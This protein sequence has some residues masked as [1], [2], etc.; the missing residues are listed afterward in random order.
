MGAD[1]CEVDLAGLFRLF[2]LRGCD[3]MD[4]RL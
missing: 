3:S 1:D 2:R 4:L